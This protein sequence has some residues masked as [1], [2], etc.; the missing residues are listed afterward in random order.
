MKIIQNPHKG[1]AKLAN[2]ADYPSVNAKRVHDLLS[3]CPAFKTTPMVSADNLIN[4]GALF[5]KDERKRMNVGSFK[6]LGAAYVI[7]TQAAA[8]DPKPTAETLKG[9][10]Y[11]TASAGNH[12]ISVAAGARVFGAD[13]VVY[14]AKTVPSSFADRLRGIG[15]DVRIE[16]EDYAASMEAAMKA[17]DDHGWTLLSDISWEGYTEIP[18]TLMEGYLQMVAEAVDQLDAPPTHLFLQAGVGGLACAAAAY[19][20]HVWGDAPVIAVVEP[21]NA[22]ALQ[23]SIEAGKSVY[24]DGPDSVMGR[25]DCKEP[26]L[27]ALNGL[28]RDADHFITLSDE[29]VLTHLPAMEE[30]NIATSSSGGAGI[31]AA[32]HN[33]VADSLGLDANARI[34]TFLSEGPA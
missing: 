13:A 34:L 21:E 1:G 7:A 14:L 12:G 18:F 27:I 5:V 31:A 15:A 20:R 29:E 4:G 32:M 8:K 16:G 2:A 23:A 3:Q 26:S 25:L 9:T 17:A 11:V 19:A 6:A 30:A 33:G 10:T 28:A 24:T 22:P